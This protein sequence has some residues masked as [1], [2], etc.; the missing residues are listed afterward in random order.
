MVPL[1]GKELKNFL[2]VPSLL[3]IGV[4]IGCTIGKQGVYLAE[5]PTKPI[6]TIQQDTLIIKTQN[7]IR[8]SALLIYQINISIDNA[9]KKIY[10]SAYQALNKTYQDTFTIKLDDYKVTEPDLFEY[11]WRDPDNRTTKLEIIF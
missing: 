3:A 5:M 1:F 10:L 8:H 11:Y 4:L 6:L 7:S 2:A 9:Q